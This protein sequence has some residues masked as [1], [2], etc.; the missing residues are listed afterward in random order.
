MPADL[1]A[2]LACEWRPRLHNRYTCRQLSPAFRDS[3]P[4]AMACRLQPYG[5]APVSHGKRCRQTVLDLSGSASVPP[6]ST[7]VVPG[8]AFVR[9]SDGFLR[10]PGA[11][12]A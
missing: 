9:V 12:I 11:T 10:L 4:K 8:L 3:V 2:A 6:P 5:A 7:Q 1:R